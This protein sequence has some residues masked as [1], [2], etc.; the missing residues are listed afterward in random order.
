MSSTIPADW[1]WQFPSEFEA[2]SRQDIYCNKRQSV[3]ELEGDASIDGLFDFAV[4][5]H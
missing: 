1:I 2:S 3:C 5:S 4:I